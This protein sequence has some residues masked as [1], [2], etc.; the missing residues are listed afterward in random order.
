MGG[1]GGAWP[2]Q[3]LWTWG[4]NLLDARRGFGRYVAVF[5]VVRSVEESEV[6]RYNSCSGERS[7]EYSRHGQA[8]VSSWT[9]STDA[10]KERNGFHVQTTAAVCLRWRGRADAYVRPFR[11]AF[12]VDML[13][14]LCPDG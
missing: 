10:A 14:R 13:I 2:F 7:S 1:E 11:E 4:Q 5:L 12:N 9:S 8:F 6:S 3:T